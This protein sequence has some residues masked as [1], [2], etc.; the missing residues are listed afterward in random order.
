MVFPSMEIKVKKA[1][2]DAL[3]EHMSKE[4]AL[5]YNRLFEKI[6]GEVKSRATFQKYL[7]KLENAGVIKKVPDPAHGKA[8][9]IYRTDE[10]NVEQLILD[11]AD[12]IR[13]VLSR[14]NVEK[15]TWDIYGKFPP[16][17]WERVQKIINVVDVAH[18]YLFKALNLPQADLWVKT[19]REN[20]KLILKIRKSS[21]TSHEELN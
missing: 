2:L 16:E 3:K 14:G 1:I 4:T 13:D 15:V 5:G 6:K 10:A 9:L 12:K 18:T 19:T 21:N 8:V 20:G 11:M 7:T 17:I